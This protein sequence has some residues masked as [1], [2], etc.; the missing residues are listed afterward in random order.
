MRL[1]FETEGEGDSRAERSVDSEEKSLRKSKGIRPASSGKVRQTSPKSQEKVD[2]GSGQARGADRR[3][4]FSRG[5]DPMLGRIRGRYLGL[6]LDNR[7]TPSPCPKSS[8]SLVGLDSTDPCHLK[9]ARTE[10]GLSRGPFPRP[11][12]LLLSRA[13]LLDL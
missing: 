5:S 10:I 7:A 4:G 11:L 6:G 8:P 13:L 2:L 1:G 12:C 9:E 3:S